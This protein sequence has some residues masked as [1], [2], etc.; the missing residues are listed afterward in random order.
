MT[1]MAHKGPGLSGSGHGDLFHGR[2]ERLSP[3]YHPCPGGAGASERCQ[4]PASGHL[5]VVGVIESAEAGNLKPKEILADSLYGS[6]DN[7]QKAE[8]HDVEVVAPVMGETK[9]DG[10]SLS[11]FQISD[12][13]LVLACPLGQAPAKVKQG[14]PAVGGQARRRRTSAAASALTRPFAIPAPSVPGVR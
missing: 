5:C 4:C 11:D 1:P 12:K 8:T 6:D 10:F 7:C 9:K 2:Q 13:G 14:K 3:A